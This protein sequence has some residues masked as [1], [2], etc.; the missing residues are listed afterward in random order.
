MMTDDIGDQAVP[1][2]AED[3]CPGCAAHRAGQEPQTHRP[4]FVYAFGNI[5]ATFPD[6]GV[7]KEYAQ[8]VGV[9][10]TRNLTDRQTLHEVL[11][12]PENLYL[13]RQMCYVFSICGVATYLLRPRFA[14]DYRQLVDAVRPEPSPSDIDV[15]IGQLEGIAS[16]SECGGLALPVVTMEHLYSFDDATL[17]GALEQPK[18]MPREGFET[19]AKELLMR[20]MQMT[21]NTGAS[22]TY[23]AVNFLVCRYSAVYVKTFEMFTRD[24]SLTSIDVRPSRLSGVR[25]IV[26]VVLTYTYRDTDVSEKYFVRLDVTYMHPW[27]VTKLSPYY[28]RA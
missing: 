25:E 17:V 4:A 19:A 23:R 3:E 10:P 16:P 26:D 14:E 6:L 2:T 28:D 12:Q 21:D 11:S 22:P 24:A 27:V 9:S 20:V 1:T 5:Q 13:A 7:E 15:I 8:V 18:G